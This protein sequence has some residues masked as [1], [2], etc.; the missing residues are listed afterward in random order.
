[1][2]A[3][4]STALTTG[5]NDQYWLPDGVKILVESAGTGT[6]FPTD[7]STVNVFYVGRLTNG[8]VFDASQFHGS[9]PSSFQVSNVV[10][11]FG[12]ALKLMR[13]G[14]V[15]RV[16]IPSALAYGDSPPQGA[17]I[18]PNADLVFDIQLVSFT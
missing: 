8:T 17:G 14:D 16:F 10:P 13:N 9:G 6:T 5:T 11:G 1:M 2:F 18:P 4:G 15:F 7:S 3:G 12:E